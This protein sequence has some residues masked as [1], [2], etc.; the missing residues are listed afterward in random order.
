MARSIDADHLISRIM[1][2]KDEIE[3]TFVDGIVQF[4][5]DEET[6]ENEIKWIKRTISKK[7]KT[8]NA[9]NHGVCCSKCGHFQ[10]FETAYCPDCGGHFIGKPVFI[11]HIR[12][13]ND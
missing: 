7:T 13:F 8:C 4:I 12:M 1:T 2:P 3:K 6:Y 5:N 11:N 10:L 9:S